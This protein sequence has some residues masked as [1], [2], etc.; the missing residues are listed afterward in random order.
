MA[1]FQAPSPAD[2]Q[3]PSRPLSD[4]RRV[5]PPRRRGPHVRHGR[6]TANRRSEAFSGPGFRDQR[7][8]ARR[9]GS[10]RGPG[11]E[12]T[13]PPTGDCQCK[14][15]RSIEGGGTRS[16]DHRRVAARRPGGTRPG[17]RG[18]LEP[19]RLAH[20]KVDR[21]VDTRAR[22]APMP[23]QLDR[24]RQPWATG[25]GAR[26]RRRLR[27]GLGQRRR[28]RGCEEL[29]ALARLAGLRGTGPVR[30]CRRQARGECG[31]GSVRAAD[32]ASGGG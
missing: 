4:A 5:N 27:P 3:C 18:H 9:R 20:A 21:A 10:A 16:A 11:V 13:R 14:R 31:W 15:L 6:R 7:G 30:A 24:A 26:L 28:G 8:T 32:R 1:G 25:G 22:A 17:E 12:P 19:R 23:L 29:H 2:F